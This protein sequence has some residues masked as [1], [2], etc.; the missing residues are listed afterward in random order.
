[1]NNPTI[2]IIIPVYNDPEGIRITLDSLLAQSIDTRYNITVVDNNSTD[3]TPD[4]VSSYQKDHDNLTLIHETEIQSSY[5][6]RNTGVRNTNAEIIAFIDA[7]MT[8]PE[9]Y[10]ENIHKIFQS[11]GVD[12][13]GC[14]VNLILPNEP[15]LAARYDY[16]TGFPINEYL[17]HQQFAPTCCLVVLRNV[18]EA[19]GVFD[20]QLISGG[21]KEFGN[22]VN[23]SGY[24]QHFAEDVKM[25]HPTRNSLTSL[26]SK[27]YRVGRGLC[28][29]QR[30]HPDRYGIPG[31]PPQPTGIKQPSRDLSIG[32]WITFSVLSTALTGV[33]AIGYY[34]EYLSKITRI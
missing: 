11:T 1:M 18:F 14:D 30:N 19:V 5:A 12:Y 27:D 32:D 20:E 26:I 34:H 17:T 23:E 9:N 4:V 33:R 10:L 21:D 25:Y 29:V 31:T 22:R 6:A 2:D 8:V 13:M 15:S 3:K 7:D 24:N 28:Q 16:H